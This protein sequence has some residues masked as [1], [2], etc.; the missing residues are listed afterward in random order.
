MAVTNK[1]LYL[2]TLTT[3][4]TTNLYTVTTGATAIVKEILV[5]NNDSSARTFTLSYGTAASEIMMFDAITIQAG[6]T[7]LFGTATVL[8]SA[9][10][11]DGGASVNSQVTIIISG[12]EIT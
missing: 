4:L 1:Q 10:V 12:V 2:G 7:K 8:N 3:T 5:S 11:I 9:Q 6:E